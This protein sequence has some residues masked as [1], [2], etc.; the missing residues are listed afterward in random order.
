MLVPPAIAI[1][2]LKRVCAGLNTNERWQRPLVMTSAIIFPFDNFGG[3]GTGA[4]AQLLGDALREILDDNDAETAPTRADCYKG[5]VE[6]HE[7]EF[8]TAKQLAD[9]RKHGRSLAK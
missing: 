4:G 1:W 3:A 2:S 6:I 7:A 5:Q 8:Q 9:W